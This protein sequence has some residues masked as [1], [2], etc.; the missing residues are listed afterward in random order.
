MTDKSGE[1]EPCTPAYMPL[2]VFQESGKRTIGLKPLR[3]AGVERC[4]LCNADL[5]DEFIPGFGLAYGGYG[6][7]WYCTSDDCPWFYKIMEGG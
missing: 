6:L 2:V 4:P 3:I 7:Y 5:T 1:R